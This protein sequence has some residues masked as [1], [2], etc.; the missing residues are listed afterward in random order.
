MGKISCYIK[1]K[2]NGCKIAEVREITKLFNYEQKD[3]N[4]EFIR[5]EHFFLKDI[6]TLRLTNA[7]ALEFYRRDVNPDKSVLERVDEIVQ[8]AA[9]SFSTRINDLSV[10]FDKPICC[11]HTAS[12]LE[13]TF[14]SIPENV[15]RL[16][17]Q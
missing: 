14:E 15:E 4:G 12:F 8:E 5:P 11:A 3:G 9:D 13:K 16:V 2:D 6:F 17:E 10:N 7:Y 1:I